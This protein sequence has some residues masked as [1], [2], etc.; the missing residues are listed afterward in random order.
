MKPMTY[1]AVPEGLPCWCRR[2]ACSS[3]A[4]SRTASGAGHAAG[5]TTASAACSCR[6]AGSSRHT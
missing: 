4:V 6:S 3:S 5:T 2:A 1:E